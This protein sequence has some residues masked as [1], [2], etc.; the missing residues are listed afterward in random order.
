MANSVDMSKLFPGE[1]YCPS[2][3]IPG[4]YLENGVNATSIRFDSANEYFI[5]CR[6]FS[7]CYAIAIR[8]L[9]AQNE[10]AYA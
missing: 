4:F 10:R 7:R 3:K 6:I 2:P 9:Q 5:C 8:W 1:C